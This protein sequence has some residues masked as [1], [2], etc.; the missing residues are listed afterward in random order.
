M[1]TVMYRVLIGCIITD[2]LILLMI[3]AIGKSTLRPRTSALLE[4]KITIMLPIDPL[5]QANS[6]PQTHFC[7]G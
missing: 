3:G 1:I 5:I 7:C 4:K 2:Q 6:R